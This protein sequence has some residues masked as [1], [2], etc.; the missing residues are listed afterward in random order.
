MAIDINKLKITN[1][2]ADR[3]VERCRPDLTR[4]TAK[5]EI[6]RVARLGPRKIQLDP[7]P[8]IETN[9]T[10]AEASFYMELSEG[11]A[12][13]LFWSK[14]CYVASTVFVRS[15]TSPAKRRHRNRKRAARNSRKR[16]KARRKTPKAYQRTGDWTEE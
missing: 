9:G 3:Y 2:A 8:W 4:E 16:A 6:L 15:G 14:N 11:I 12:L 13:G 5:A 7:F 10:D 1:H